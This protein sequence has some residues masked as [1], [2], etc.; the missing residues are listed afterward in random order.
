MKR[1]AKDMLELLGIAGGLFLL[2]WLSQSWFV[3]LDLTEDQRFTLSDATTALV[4]DIDEPMLFVIYLDGDLPSGFERLKAETKRML[5]EFQVLNSNV[6]IRF[7]NPSDNP[8]PQTRRDTYTQLRNQGLSAIQI[9]IE[10]VDGVRKQQIFPGAMASHKGRIWPVQLLIEQFATAPETQINASV[11]NLEYVLASALRGL[12]QPLTKH[13]AFI[14][15]HNGLSEMETASLES[16][17]ERSYQ[18]SHFN[19][20]EYPVDSL[21]GGIS[22]DL[23]MRQLNAYDL[24][25][26]AKPRSMFSDLDLWLLDQY[27]MRNGRA[28]FLVEAVHAELD[29]L[30]FAPEFLAYPILDA[31]GLDAP[32]FNY[33]VRVNTALLQDLVC[34]GIPSD[35]SRKTLRPWAYFPLFLPQVEHP[36]AKNLNA[37]RMEFPTTMDT[38]AV[39]GVKKTALLLSSPYSKRQPTPGKVSLATLFNE[40]DRSRFQESALPTAMLLEGALPSF[41][42]NRITPIT[43]LGAAPDVAR[44][45]KLLVVADGDFIKNQRNLVIPDIPRGLPLPLG[46]DQF[47]RQQFGNQDFMLN[48][49]DY[50][51]EGGGLIDVRGRNIVMR[52]LD[53]QR[54]QANRDLLIWGNALLPVLIVLLLTR[55]YQWRHRRRSHQHHTPS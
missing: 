4:E 26:M 18:V 27:L 20:R 34:A 29:S 41:Y 51:L 3:R 21:T 31:T 42:A 40:P 6:Q 46:F 2:A 24:I 53:Q 12:T 22:L 45:A 49:V 14:D 52:L 16:V 9:E 50:L 35:V 33:G 38:I 19:L 32:L 17:L 48:A 37:I 55:L 47:S 43:S 39:P 54:I 8:D 25:I 28:I 11:Q 15:G 7:E 36:I 44:D 5:E 10:Q 23:Q 30:S 13:I 1:S